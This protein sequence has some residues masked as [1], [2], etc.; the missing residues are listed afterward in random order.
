MIAEI[1]Y[2]ANAIK[3]HIGNASQIN[4]FCNLKGQRVEEINNSKTMGIT[5][6]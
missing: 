3:N 5:N 6:V 2:A 1:W 4:S